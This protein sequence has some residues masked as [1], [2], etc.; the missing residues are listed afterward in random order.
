MV[1]ATLALPVAGSMR[2]IFLAVRSV[3]HNILSGPQVNSHGLPSPE[4]NTVLRN[5]LGPCITVSGPS[6]PD[7]LNENNTVNE[8]FKARRFIGSSYSMRERNR[9]FQVTRQ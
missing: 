6:W 4:A 2:V 1:M 8:N 3:T 7:R 9:N 5:C